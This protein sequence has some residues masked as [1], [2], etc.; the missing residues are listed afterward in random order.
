[1]SEEK[2]TAKR[3]YDLN[4]TV[5]MAVGL[6]EKAP[7]EKQ[8]ECAD[9]IIEKVQGYGI[10]ITDNDLSEFINVFRRWYDKNKQIHDALEYLK[11]SPTDVQVG[12]CL[13]LMEKLDSQT[14]NSEEINK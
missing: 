4:P 3:W 11:M 10:K 13:D 12:I 9:F 7:L 5:S 6:M 8:L 14:E 1:M 2:R